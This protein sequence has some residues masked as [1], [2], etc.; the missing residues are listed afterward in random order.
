MLTPRK[1]GTGKLRS[2][3]AGHAKQETYIV[4]QIRGC[5][6]AMTQLPPEPE[7]RQPSAWTFFTNHAH[8]LF[9][10]ALD[11]ELRIRDLA[12]RV[13]ITERAAQRIVHEL[14]R[15]GY[16]AIEREGRR[17]RYRVVVERPLRH[18]VESEHT[19]EQL[20]TFLRG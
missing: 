2:C 13:G 5:D 9:C 18:P 8:V 17:N 7:A 1:K 14:E 19:V 10:V 12:M 16:L 3:N 4:N 15:D 11:P 20:L 6:S